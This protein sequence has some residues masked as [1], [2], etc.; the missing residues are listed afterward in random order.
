M[1]SPHT[2]PQDTILLVDDSPE[3]IDILGAILRPFYRVKFATNGL[4]ALAIARRSPPSLILLDVM[5][6]GM[7]G[8]E[9]CR[10]LKADLRTRDVPILFVTA[11]GDATDE[12]LGLELGAVDYLHKPLNPPLVLQRVRIHLELRNQNLAL[13]EKVRERTWQLEE[14]RLEIVRRLALA[15]EYRDNETGLHV[16]RMSYMAHRLALAIGVPESQ[17][18]ILFHAAPMHDIG[19]IGIPDHILLKRGK[20]E[21]D[22]WVTM[23]THTLIGAEI[24][25]HH[26][27]PLLQM[28]RSVA[29]THHE[30]WDG[31]GYPKGLAGDTIPLEGRLVA[32]ADVYDALTSERPY[33]LAWTP[34]EAFAYIQ[35]QSGQHFDPRLASLFLELKSE[36]VEIGMAYGESAIPNVFS[37][38]T[39]TSPPSNPSLS[40]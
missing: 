39:P 16:I 15:G 38:L 29:L 33:K 27:S 23:K 24:I 4:D 34:D 11:S 30:K 13:E 14:T 18:E 5:M 36:I 26:D 8:H 21:P 10:H 17:A 9:V 37:C 22:E 28:A 3:M 35:D 40:S 2:N 20:L 31:S 25:G 19:K 12:Q 1:L 32:V 6:P 7:S